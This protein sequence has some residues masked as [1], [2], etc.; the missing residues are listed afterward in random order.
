MTIFMKMIFTFG[1]QVDFTTKFN[2]QKHIVIFTKRE[3]ARITNFE[4]ERKLHTEHNDFTN[5]NIFS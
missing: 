3:I 2:K 1:F 4:Y 5:A